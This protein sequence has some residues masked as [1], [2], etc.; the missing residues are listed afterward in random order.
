VPV[1]S[2]TGSGKSGACASERDILAR[3]AARDDIRLIFDKFSRG[4]V[5]VDR[6]ARPMLGEHALAERIN[7]DEGDRRCEAS[8]LKPQREPAD[9]REQAKLAKHRPSGFL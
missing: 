7:F 9:T 3:E 2:R 4:N 1:E 6:H 5:A 8:A